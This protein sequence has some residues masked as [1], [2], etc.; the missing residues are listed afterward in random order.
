[1]IRFNKCKP[2]EG[3]RAELPLLPAEHASEPPE[4]LLPAAPVRHPAA[5]LRHPPPGGAVQPAA[6]GQAGGPLEVAGDGFELSSG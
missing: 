4:P 5:R 3:S 6:D 2:T 1:M